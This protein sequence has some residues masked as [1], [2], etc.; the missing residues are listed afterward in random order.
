MNQMGGSL[1]Q[2]YQTFHR[3]PKRPA[4]L[5]PPKSCD[6]QF[7]VFGPMDKYPIRAGAVYCTPEATIEA[8]LAM[9]KVLGIERGVIVQSSAYSTDFRVLYDALAIAGPQYQGCVVLDDEV[10]DAELRR[11][12]DAG[13]RGVRFNFWKVLNLV[14]S[15]A[16]FERA[17]A[18]VGEMG[19]YVKLHMPVDELIEMQDLFRALK[20]K[21]IL[22]HFGRTEFDRGTAHPSVA[23]VDGLLR[24]GNWWMMLSNGD[25]RSKAGRPWDDAVTFARHFMDTAPDRMIWGSDWPHPLLAESEPPKDDGELLEFAYGYAKNEA[26]KQKLLVDNPAE[27]FGFK[28]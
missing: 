3:Q 6:S 26:L 13:V 8:A 24:E 18:R 9:H 1:I 25:R 2:K 7:H 10:S 4:V 12:H 15:R 11:L 19:W 16:S 22:D 17:I 5:P 23:F 28:A 14:P 27:I 20:V 21:L